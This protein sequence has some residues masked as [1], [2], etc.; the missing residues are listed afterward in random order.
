MD[1]TTRDHL[2]ALATA[3]T[4][5]FDGLHARSRS[6]RVHLVEPVSVLGHDW[7]GL[8]CHS[9]VYGGELSGLEPTAAPV[10]CR[11]CLSTAAP[12]EDSSPAQ[13]TLF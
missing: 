2:A 3:R 1:Q 9:G 12:G 8:R 13:P 6:G 5:A 10:T 11:L 4:R 7:P